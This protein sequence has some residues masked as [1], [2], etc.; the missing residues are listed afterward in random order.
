[1]NLF[2][3]SVNE[4]IVGSI[5]CSKNV[6]NGKKKEF[7]TPKASLKS[8]CFVRSP[9]KRSNFS[10]IKIFKKSSISEVFVCKN[11]LKDN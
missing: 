4:L 5:K 8:S 6:L 1:M 9:V 11:Y 10:S 7:L 3:S 2:L